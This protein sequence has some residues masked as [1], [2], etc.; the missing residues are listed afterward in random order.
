MCSAQEVRPRTGVYHADPYRIYRHR[1][2]PTGQR[3]VY[4]RVPSSGTLCDLYLSP[5]ELYLIQISRVS[6]PTSPQAPTQTLHT[7]SN[8]D[9]HQRIRTSITEY[10]SLQGLH[11]PPT[12][13]RATPRPMTGLSTSKSRCDRS[14][15]GQSHPHT[16]SDSCAGKLRACSTLHITAFPSRSY[17]LDSP[18]HDAACIPHYP[19]QYPISFPRL[20]P[21]AE[22]AR[23]GL[24]RPRWRRRY[25]TTVICSVHAF[26]Y[27]RVRT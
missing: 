23:Q 17:H 22:T 6:S 8:V 21:D 19:S 26:V 20:H 9:P 10:R 2:A 5:R 15:F 7:D 14:V 1:R 12:I 4:L 25:R 18:R 16:P 3:Y 24:S 11:T 13:S 27:R